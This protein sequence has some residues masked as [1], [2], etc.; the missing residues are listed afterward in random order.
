[1]EDA[2]IAIGARSSI[3]EPAAMRSHKRFS[4]Q[5]SFWIDAKI[6]N[7]PIDE[8]RLNRRGIG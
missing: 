7:S 1:V 4:R 3:R 2:M 8:A 6:A 5:H